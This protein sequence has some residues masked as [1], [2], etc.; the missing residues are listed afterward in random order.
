[1]TTADFLQAFSLLIGLEHVLLCLGSSLEG[2]LSSLVL[3]A[4]QDQ[5][6]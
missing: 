4:C 5:Q 1:M 2:W 6:L 3:E